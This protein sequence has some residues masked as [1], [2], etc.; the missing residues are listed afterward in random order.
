MFQAIRFV[1]NLLEQPQKTD[2]QGYDPDIILLPSL[3]ASFNQIHPS[4]N[5]PFVFLSVRSQISSTHYPPPHF[6]PTEQLPLSHLHWLLHCQGLCVKV[7]GLSPT[8][9][10]VISHSP[11]ALNAIHRRLTNVYICPKPL[12]LLPNSYIQLLM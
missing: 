4:R 1:V 8:S 3:S 10:L 2:T 12:H 6:P 9:N 7:P 5:S 11:M